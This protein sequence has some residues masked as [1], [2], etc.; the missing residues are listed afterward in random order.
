M[1]SVAKV[2]VWNRAL[3][4][5]GSAKIEDPADLTVLEAAECEEAWEDVLEAALKAFPWRFARRQ[6]QLSLA[7]SDYDAATTYAADALARSDEG[8]IYKSVSGG[9]GQDL[10]DP[11]Y[12]TYQ[13]TIA[14]GWAYVYPLPDDCVQPLALLSEGQ[15]LGNMPEASRIPFEPYDASASTGQVIGSDAD[16]DDFDFL[17]YTCRHEQVTAWPRAFVSA[18]AYALAAELALS[19][20]KEP[21]LSRSMMEAYR[22]A[23]S[24]AAAVELNGRQEE[25]E[26]VTP[27]IA[28]R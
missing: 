11:T 21:L 14:G 9:T 7:Y 20:K 18:V 27:S 10:T 17:E 13:Y 6:A 22:Q 24:E 25:P 3:R 4:R 23:L 5:I 8:H 2:H 28:A 16:T 12:W 1:R 19:L 26:P 15:R